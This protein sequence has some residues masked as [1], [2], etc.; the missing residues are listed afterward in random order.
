MED[1]YHVFVRCGRFETLREE[2]SGL[3]VKKVE[4]WV[5]EYK[6]EESHLMGLRKAAESFFHDSDTL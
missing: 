1:M 3:I 2:A 5:E 4:K 6:L